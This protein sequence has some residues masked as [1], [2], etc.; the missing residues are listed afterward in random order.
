MN[1]NRIRRFFCYSRLVSLSA[2]GIFAAQV[3]PAKEVLSA[4]YNPT[5]EN[6]AL[7]ERL[8]NKWSSEITATHADIVKWAQN[9]ENYKRM[10]PKL[11]NFLDKNKDAYKAVSS[12]S[13]ILYRDNT[14][15]FQIKMQHEDGYDGA[16][17]LNR[18]YFNAPE[19]AAWEYKQTPPV[20]PKTKKPW[21]DLSKEEIRQ[22]IKETKQT[23]SKEDVSYL[24][25]LM[26]ILSENF[27]FYYGEQFVTT[28]KIKDPSA[29]IGK[30]RPMKTLMYA[31][32]DDFLPDEP[33]QKR[34]LSQKLG[35]PLYHFHKGF[36]ATI[37]LGYSGNCYGHA[38]VELRM[39]DGQVHSVTYWNQVSG[40]DVNKKRGD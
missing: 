4:E 21:I 11:K 8:L 29:L 18:T 7:D 40:Q 16:L 34:E 27:H 14:A 5:M 13:Y 28:D 25:D 9:A 17:F 3:L 39:K 24:K 2:L 6:N 19:D 30:Y 35:R 1:A 31:A 20:N 22:I 36:D 26:S 23:F 32:F 15:G 37:P 10:H 38:T 12:V 33:A